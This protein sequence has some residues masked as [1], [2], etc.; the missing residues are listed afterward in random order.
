M[1]AQSTRMILWQSV[2]SAL[3]YYDLFNY[4]LR[5]SEVFRFMGTNHVN[6]KDVTDALLDLCHMNIVYQQ[7]DFFTLQNNEWI[8]IRRL[9]GNAEA[10]KYLLL[11]KKKAKMIM[12]F[13]FVRAVFVSGSLSKNYIDEKSD[14][15]FFIV[16]APNKLWIARFLLGAYKKVFLFNSRKHF[17]INY[18]VD[19]EHLAIA[20]KNI[21]TA[22]ELATAIPLQGSEYYDRLMDSNKWLKNFFPNYLPQPISGLPVGGTGTLKKAV[23]FLINLLAFRWLDFL[24]M[25][26]FLARWRRQYKANH[27]E[28]DFK[29]AFKTKKHVSKSHPKHYQKK[30]LQLYEER[31]SEIG[32]KFPSIFNQNS[33]TA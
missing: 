12:Q 15:D 14:I 24:L 31:L 11:A 16:T 27:S 4:P 7:G 19:T 22:T 17:C 32:A 2:L 33:K 9:K 18:F 25:N 5:S 21:F 23:E 26:L 13:P 8:T 6:E 1:S 28:T 30:V 10:E 29:I 20:E 3:A